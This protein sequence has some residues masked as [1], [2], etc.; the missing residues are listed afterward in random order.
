MSVQVKPP[1]AGYVA[2]AYTLVIV[3]ASAQPFSGWRMPPPEVL[4]F[5]TAPWPRYLTIGDI[6]LN[7]AAYLPLGA[8]LFFVLRPPLAAAFAMVLATMLGV[9]LSL[10]LEIVQ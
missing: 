3:Y 7:I 8:M 6:L 5:L 10:V 4:A 2:L 9:L 1:L